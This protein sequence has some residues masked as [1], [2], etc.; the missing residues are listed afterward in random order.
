M[1]GGTWSTKNAPLWRWLPSVSLPWPSLLSQHP[2]VNNQPGRP[3][4]FYFSRRTGLRFPCVPDK[5][6]T[7]IPCCEHSNSSPGGCLSRS[8]NGS[9]PQRRSSSSPHTSAHNMLKV[10]QSTEI[11]IFCTFYQIIPTAGGETQAGLFPTAAPCISPYQLLLKHPMIK[12]LI[13]LNPKQGAG[14]KL[15]AAAV[16]AELTSQLAA[17]HP[18][19][20]QVRT[21]TIFCREKFCD[22]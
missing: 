10:P 9:S 15:S 4:L 12:C 19:N 3:C 17:N 2:A 13:Q 14:T 5:L 22:L 11:V 1:V 7:V 6:H 20:S 8:S 16:H 18:G 21:E